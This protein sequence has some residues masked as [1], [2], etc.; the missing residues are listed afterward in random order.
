MTW[1]GW[2]AEDLDLELVAAVQQSLRDA[3]ASLKEDNWMYEPET[4]G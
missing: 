4:D 2:R 1:S 3:V